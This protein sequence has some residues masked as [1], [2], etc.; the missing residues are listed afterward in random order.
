MFYHYFYATTVPPSIFELADRSNMT[1]L[2]KT[3]Q[4]ISYSKKLSELE[5]E[6]HAANSQCGHLAR[7]KKLNGYTVGILPA[8][9]VPHEG[10]ICCISSDS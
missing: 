6:Y 4:I 7:Y 2:Y 9:G 3:L 10:G 1:L 5:L 8:M